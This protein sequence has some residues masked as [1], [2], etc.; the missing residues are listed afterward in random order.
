MNPEQDLFGLEDF[1]QKD[2]SPEDNTQITTTI[3]YYSEDELKEFKK[4]AKVAIKKQLGD[5]FKDGN[6]SDLILN[7]LRNEC[8]SN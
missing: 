8:K 7:L 3:L 6:I 5:N 2:N 4:L 1:L